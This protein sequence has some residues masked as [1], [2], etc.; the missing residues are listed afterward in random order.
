MKGKEINFNEFRAKP[1]KRP[2]YKQA[3]KDKRFS[4]NRNITQEAIDKLN[5]R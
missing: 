1:V 2:E 5:N 3:I 4:D